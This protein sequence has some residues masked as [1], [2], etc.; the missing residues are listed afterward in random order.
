MNKLHFDYI[1]IGAGAA[2]L[3]LARAMTEDAYF[4]NMSILV[5]DKDQKKENDRTWCFWEKGQG[6]FDSIVHR[7]W[8][9]ICFMGQNISKQFEI[10][11]YRYKMV[12]G[13]DFYKEYLN[14]L[15]NSHHID[16]RYEE[17]VEMN[18]IGTNITVKTR[19]NRYT[20]SKVFNSI[21][22]LKRAKAQA[23]YP[24][25]Q[26]H[27]VGWF[28]KTDRP[29][30]NSEAVT[31]MDFTVP[32]K[33]NTRF[34]YVLPLSEREALVEYTLFSEDPLPKEAYEQALENY[35]D[36]NLGAPQ[37][38]IIEREEGR[39]PM[40]CYDF[41]QHN[42]QRLLHIGTAGGWAKPSTGYTFMPTAKKIPIVIKALKTEKPL[43][44][45]RFKNRF[46]YYD[47]L[48]L[49][50]LFHQNEKG[51]LIF[52]SLFKNKPPRLILKFLD[53]ETSFIQDLNLIWGCPKLV[54]VK[55]L[56]KRLSYQYLSL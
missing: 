37:Y 38:E 41:S 7:S 40:T 36:T 53:E 55:I 25:L 29:V 13:I 45:I 16:I 47:L 12:R 35:I 10:S 4:S 24:V 3:M 43:N 44:S 19:K 51:H 15:E 6:G 17:V 31:Y 49:D 23:N 2:G 48:F 39:I 54:F 34:M 5:L 8:D 28:I 1:I 50:V 22:S 27:F 46:W 32:Q 33:G 52:E 42:T 11:P 56:Y 21:F 9:Q 20:A 26:Q 18:D 30:F 14:I